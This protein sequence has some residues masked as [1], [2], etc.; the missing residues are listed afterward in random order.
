[1][2][3]CM[4]VCMHVRRMHAWGLRRLGEVWADSPNWGHTQLW[5]A[6]LWVL[7]EAASALTVE[8]S[9]QPPPSPHFA[10]LIIHLAVEKCLCFM[11]SICLSVYVVIHLSVYVCFC[12]PWFGVVD[13]KSLHSP[14]TL[15]G[16]PLFSSNVSWLCILLLLSWWWK[17]WSSFILLHVDTQFSS[18][19]FAKETVL[20]PVYALR[21]LSEYLLASIV[22]E[23]SD[24]FCQ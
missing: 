16:S 21:T 12:F 4:Y 1:M 22:F 8:S 10:V 11:S 6:M 2:Y 9:L 19:T 14:T 3:V 5:A 13:G 20:F 23:A 17:T 18:E 15:S 24:D 7:W